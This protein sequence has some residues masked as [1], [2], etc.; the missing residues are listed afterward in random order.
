MV[1]LATEDGMIEAAPGVAVG[2][3][4]LVDL[5]TRRTVTLRHL[6]TGVVHE[7]E[8][9]MTYPPAGWLCTEMLELGGAP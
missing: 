3:T 9:V 5:A 8:I 2:A 7:K 4:Y 1:K 6:V